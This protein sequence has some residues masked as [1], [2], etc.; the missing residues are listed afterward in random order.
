M[1]AEHNTL[2]HRNPETATW[3]LVHENGKSTAHH[4]LGRGG[5]GFLQQPITKLHKLG[6]SDTNTV[7]A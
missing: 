6:F 2:R 4:S 1:R 7:G 5:A 3:W